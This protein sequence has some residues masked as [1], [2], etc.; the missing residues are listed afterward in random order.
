[1]QLLQKDVVP[2]A[3]GWFADHI[4]NQGDAQ[5]ESLVLLDGVKGW[6]TAGDE[7]VQSMIAY[8]ASVWSAK[9]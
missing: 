3:A 2:R 7:Y 8:D 5:M 9:Q 1:M 6:A 4:A